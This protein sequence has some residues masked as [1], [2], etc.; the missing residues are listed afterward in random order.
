MPDS[1]LI[2]LGQCWTSVSPFCWWNM[3]KNWALLKNPR[4]FCR[5]HLHGFW[6]SRWHFWDDQLLLICQLTKVLGHAG[7]VMGVSSRPV[8]GVPLKMV[9]DGFWWFFVG[10]KSDLEMDL[11]TSCSLIDG[12][13]HLKAMAF[14]LEGVRI[15]GL[16]DQGRKCRRALPHP[17]PG[18]VTVSELRRWFRWAK[19]CS[20]I[21]G[22]QRITCLSTDKF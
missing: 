15:D 8:M 3:P 19:W 10:G 14:W 7:F 6:L 5:T 12:S 21:H 18:P 17:S 2:R 13:P 11:V 20:W 1:L 4:G 9:F 22:V 16:T